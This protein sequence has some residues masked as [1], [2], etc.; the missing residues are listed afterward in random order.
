MSRASLSF[1]IDSRDIRFS[2]FDVLEVQNLLAYEKFGHLDREQIEAILTEA[3]RVAVEVVSPLNRVADQNHPTYAEGK[4]TMPPEFHSAFRR[5]CDTGWLSCVLGKEAY[6]MG[7]PEAVNMAVKEVFNG[8]CGGFYAFSS[9]TAG[10][11]HLIESFGSE[12]LKATYI[13]K[14][15]RGIY[16]GTMC[17]T[18]PEAGSYLADM[19][20][21]AIR[22]GDGFK[23]KGTKIFIGTGEHDLAENIVHCVMAR[24]EG[25]PSGYRGISLFA[26]PKHLVNADGT[27]GPPNDVTC[28]GIEDK[29]GWDGAPT[30][31]LHFGDQDRC[32]GWLLGEEGQGLTLMFQMMNELRLSTGVQGVGQAAGAYQKALAYTRQRYQGLSHKRKKDEPPIQVPIIQHPDIR[33]NLLSM[34]TAVEGCRRLIFQTALYIDL[35]MLHEDEKM[36]EY[37]G[38]LVEILTPICKA[39]ATDMGFS[40]ANTA[41]QSMGGYGYIKESGVEQYLRDLK[42]ACIYEGTNGIQAVTLQRRGLGLKDGK[43]FEQLLGEIDGFIRQQVEHPTLGSLARK[44][45][46]ARTKL[47]EAAASF[48]DAGEE[49]PGLPLSVASPFLKICGHVLSTWMLL[50]SAAVADAFLKSDGIP[51][52]DRAFYQGKIHTANF[53]VANLLPEVDAV[54]DTI[55]AR[56]RSIIDIREDSF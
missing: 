25:A 12:E 28:S 34:K 38:D 52:G 54:A 42:V 16:T 51:E 15:A 49:D 37:Y 19:T 22:E 50:K 7:L 41:I 46:E 29:M 24:I 10:A 47:A 14:M 13:E 6:G 20:T 2:L 40:A 26:V 44:L 17:L 9:L 5:Y 56:D 4:V 39:Y 8:A 1:S 43:L 35:S 32:Q 27:L 21:R 3:E 11:L 23:I 48:S 33:R 18:E 53:A 30:A 55:A 31:V 45:A 36:R